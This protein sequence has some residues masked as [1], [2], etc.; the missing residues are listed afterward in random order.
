MSHPV[1]LGPP[2]AIVIAATLL[3]LP[4]LGAA[5][6]GE[7]AGELDRAEYIAAAE[8]VCE[9]AA[10]ENIGLFRRI[11]AISP[12]EAG[13]RFV[14][15]AARFRKRFRE[16]EAVPQPTVDEARLT[17]W[18]AALNTE[19]ELLA[20][21]GSSLRADEKGRAQ[22]YAES[23]RKNANYANNLVLGFGFAYCTLDP[24]RYF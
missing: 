15:A 1:A 22:H 14:R 3:S 2:I 12:M 9:R 20:A 19:T 11:R 18:L 21:L 23:L 7:P 16:L 17:K 8:P 10:K 24:G 13:T 5:S 6:E 4:S